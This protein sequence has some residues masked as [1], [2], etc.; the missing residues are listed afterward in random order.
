MGRSAEQVHFKVR[1]L[2]LVRAYKNLGLLLFFL[3]VMG[4]RVR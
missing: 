1:F 2:V 4:K 3:R